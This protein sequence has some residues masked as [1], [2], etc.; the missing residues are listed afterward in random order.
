M[1]AIPNSMRAVQLQAY[2][3]KPE[4]IAVV[5]VPMPRPGAGEILVRMAAAPVNPSD[6]AFTRG[7]YGFK[8]PLPAIPGFEGSG[9]VVEAGGG[10]MAG[11][12]KGKRVACHAGDP[13]IAG[14]TWA[15]YLV[16]HASAAVHLRKEVDME[17]GA[18]MLVNPMTAWALVEAAREGSHP[19]I[20]QTA[21]ASAIG[22]MI[23]RLARKFSIPVIN[24]VRRAEQVELLRGMSAEHVLNSSDA[25][26]DVKLREL[27]RQLNASIGLDSVAGDMTLRVLR[28]QPKGSRM[29]VYGALAMT[30]CQVDPGSLVFERKRVEGFWVS[31]WLRQKSLLSKF[32]IAQQVQKMLAGEL[33]TEFQARFSLEEAARALQQYAANM[34]AGKVLLLP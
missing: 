14:G 33:K 32:R 2:D 34:T 3:G 31:G 29:L 12:L 30:P 16:T 26:F 4:S 11:L 19:A 27:C 15:E 20:V 7:L 25:D 28:A 18:T 17:Q 10:M 1:A 23:L 24:V 6:L 13:K 9:T 8:K 22:R 21:A 5:Q